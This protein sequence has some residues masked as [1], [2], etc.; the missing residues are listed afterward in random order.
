MDFGKPLFRYDY[1]S[2]FGISMGQT[3]TMRCRPGFARVALNTVHGLGNWTE[4]SVTVSGSLSTASGG[5][6]A[7]PQFTRQMGTLLPAVDGAPIPAP[8]D[9]DYDRVNDA[10]TVTYRCEFTSPIK[11]VKNNPPEVRY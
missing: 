10:T 2:C 9:T 5:S 1:K 6:I 3:C 4:T 8:F 7:A 11:K